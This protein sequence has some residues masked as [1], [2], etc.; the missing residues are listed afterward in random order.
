MPYRIRHK[1]TKLLMHL[2]GGNDLWSRD[3]T[4]AA[5]FPTK[6]AAITEAKKHGLRSQEYEVV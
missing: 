6:K 2:E 3:E 4:E 5:E 1:A